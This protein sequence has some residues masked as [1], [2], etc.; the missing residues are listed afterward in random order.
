MESG[1]AASS[2]DARLR[3]L[4]MPAV[5]TSAAELARTQVAFLWVPLSF[6][7]PEIARNH[8][9]H[10]WP[11][12][13]YVDSVGTTWYSPFLAVRAMD[14]FYR[15]RLWN[16]K[17]FAFGSTGSGAERAPASSTCSSASC[18]PTDGWG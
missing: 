2:I 16:K 5:R 1:C 17:P 15:Y 18:A 12:S 3:R 10:W 6:G 4:R 9:R 7:N 14:R 8:P 11:G 13:R